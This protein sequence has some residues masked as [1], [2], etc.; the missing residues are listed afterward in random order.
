MRLQTKEYRNG[1]T[2]SEW[3]LI[4][5][6]VDGEGM[7]ASTKSDDGFTMLSKRSTRINNRNAVASWVGTQVAANSPSDSTINT[8]NSSLGT[9]KVNNEATALQNQMQNV[10]S[11]IP[12][13]G[14]TLVQVMQ[15]NKK[16]I[17]GVEAS[18]IRHFVQ[19]I[20][21]QPH[22]EHLPSNISEHIES[23]FQGGG[24]NS[25]LCY[26][27]WANLYLLE[28]PKS[29]FWQEVVVEASA[30]VPED[31]NCWVLVRGDTANVYATFKGFNLLVHDQK[32]LFKA[33]AFYFSFKKGV[34]RWEYQ[35][36]ELDIQEWLIKE[37][38]PI[39]GENN[40]M[41]VSAQV[42]K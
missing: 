38:V 34:F 31:L 16:L 19:V 9:P 5:E 22:W 11:P 32:K 3:S 15:Q 35:A 18:N 14:L 7:V 25:A 10:K 4:S 29:E 8:A 42:P 2:M 1:I 36:D 13:E 37:G 41:G 30:K 40:F 33:R 12:R 17:A 23:R 28:N 39:S 21:E 26:I 24:I 27:F 6:G 20:Y